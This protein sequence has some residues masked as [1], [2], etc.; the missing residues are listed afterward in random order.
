MFKQETLRALTKMFKKNPGTSDKIAEIK[1]D[2]NDDALT[3]LAVAAMVELGV[4]VD[5]F[6]LSN[7]DKMTWFLKVAKVI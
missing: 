3:D 1:N 6:T 5:D 2:T 4:G 7:I